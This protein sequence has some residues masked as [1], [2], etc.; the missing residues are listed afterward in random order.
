MK[1]SNPLQSGSQLSKIKSYISTKLWK[2]LMPLL[3]WKKRPFSTKPS[4]LYHRCSET[5]LDVFIDC[6]VNKNLMRL[7]KFGKANAKQV[8][9]A[10]EE[11]FTDYCEILGSPQYSRMVALIKDIGGLQ[12]KM[13]AINLALRVLS[14][15]Y[16]YKCV[17]VLRKFGYNYK[18]SI[19]DPD[20]YFKDLETVQKKSKSSELALDRALLEYKALFEKSEG[21]APTYEVF[22]KNLVEL[23]KY[24]GFRINPKEVTVS[25]YVAI[26]KRREREIEL[27][28]RKQVADKKA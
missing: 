9:E 15:R 4:N 13:L 1:I 6:F 27:N 2:V 21:E 7:V 10:W 8:N 28:K 26:I 23:S 11:L 19:S 20:A 25:E 3:L 24:M 22:Q 16:S 14:V 12:S 18:F 17:Q 5:P